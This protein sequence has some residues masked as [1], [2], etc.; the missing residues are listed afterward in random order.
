MR[1]GIIGAGHIGT[2]LAHRFVDAGHDVR[3]ANSRGPET[4]TALRDEL[5][6]TPVE[7]PDAVRDVDL[8]VVTIQF[9]RVREL[10][11]GL[12]DDLPASVPVIDTNNYYHQ[13]DGE[14]APVED[15]QPESAWTAEQLG[16]PVIKAIN[17]IHAARIGSGARPEGAADRF[18]LPVAG[19]DPATKQAVLDLVASLGFDAVD[20]GTIADSWRQ[21]PGSPCYGTDLPA[22]Q[23]R[24]ALEAASQQRPAE[25]SAR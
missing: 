17:N 21:Q 24:A 8:V 11:A 14:I 1:I 15:G 22:D 5:G 7:V 6:V 20:T 18:A 10:P 4:L 2:A 12:F 19:D 25:F 23:L 3:I 13:R 16:R 9:G